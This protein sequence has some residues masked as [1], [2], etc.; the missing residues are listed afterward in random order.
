ME[1][2][3]RPADT[4]NL[5]QLE[6]AEFSADKQSSTVC[7]SCQRTISAA[8][9]ESND[10]IFCAD[11]KI[12]WEAGTDLG[13]GTGRF[14]RAFFLGLLAAIASATVYYAV[15]AATGYEFGLVALIIGLFVGC[16]VRLGSN[17]K[18]GLVYQGM[19][20]TLTYLAIVSTYVPYIMEGTK[21]ENAAEES[22]IAA[23]EPQVL[24]M[25]YAAKTTDF[26]A[27]PLE[28][29][30]NPI[31]EVIGW[32]F[33]LML[34]MAAPFL[35]GFSNVIGLVIIAI[36]LYEAWKINKQAELQFRGPY[37][38]AISPVR[39]HLKDK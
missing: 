25:A 32:A 35:A 10:K 31:A 23:R 11:C 36:G 18:G 3:T 20:V 19:A 27:A 1:Q 2:P 14:I 22:T 13:G 28:Q 6:S 30:K 16:A 9:F 37:S 5:P 15:A 21:K 17:R 8:Y 33:L 12:A 34:A 29:E 4:I 39:N 26:E 24:P 7:T 38:L